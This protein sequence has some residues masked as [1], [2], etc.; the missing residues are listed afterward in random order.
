MTTQQYKTAGEA[1][2]HYVMN[3]DRPSQQAAALTELFEII[4]AKPRRPRAKVDFIFE[5]TTNTQAAKMH[6][7]YFH[8]VASTMYDAIAQHA[9]PNA[10][11]L[12][13]IALLNEMAG[14]FNSLLELS[15]TLNQNRISAK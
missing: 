13:L 1:I 15:A 3:A 11:K 2:T 4:D 7:Y 14:Q 12:A 5:L 6:L 8:I 9:N 10:Y